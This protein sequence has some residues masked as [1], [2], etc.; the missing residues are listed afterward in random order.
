MNRKVEMAICS[1]IDNYRTWTTIVVEI[2]ANTPEDLI[3]QKVRLKIDGDIHS[4][5]PTIPY[6]QQ[7]VGSFVYFVY[8]FE[9]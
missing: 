6:A 7:I 1:E 8:P 3:E 2:P 5:Y 9:E 4:Q